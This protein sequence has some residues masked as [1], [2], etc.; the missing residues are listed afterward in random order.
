MFPHADLDGA[1]PGLGQRA[2]AVDGLVGEGRRPQDRAA[3]G[4]ERRLQMPGPEH[5]VLRAA[6]APGQLAE[7]GKA[8]AVQLLPPA[9]EDRFHIRLWPEHGLDPRGEGGEAPGAM[10]AA[11]G[12]GGAAAEPGPRRL[13]QQRRA[14]EQHRLQRRLAQIVPGEEGGAVRR[15]RRAL[16]QQHPAGKR[17]LRARHAAGRVPDTTAHGKRQWVSRR[18]KAPSI[19]SKGAMAMSVKPMRSIASAMPIL[20]SGSM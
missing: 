1:D 9:V 3:P 17:R 2:L 16:A 8:A 5:A 18:A 13:R 19:S 4:G 14:G 7:Q 11:A 10:G 6:A 15:R 20:A 12:A